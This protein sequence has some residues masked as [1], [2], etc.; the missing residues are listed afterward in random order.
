MFEN[1]SDVIFWGLAFSFSILFPVILI[2]ALFLLEKH[3]V[4]KEKK[5]PDHRRSSGK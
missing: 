2:G 1:S 5:V 3:I 4:N